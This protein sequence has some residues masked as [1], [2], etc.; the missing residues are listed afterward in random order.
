MRIHS[1][2]TVILIALCAVTNSHATSCDARGLIATQTSISRT[3]KTIE[4][5]TSV[6]P[7]NLSVVSSTG[8]LAYRRLLI[9]QEGTVQSMAPIEDLIFSYDKS[10]GQVL[11]QCE[12][13]CWRHDFSRMA[14]HM[15][16]IELPS[17]QDGQSLVVDLKQLQCLVKRGKHQ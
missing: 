4:P 7:L 3:I 15:I 12:W 6:K 8:L 10:S 1:R 16:V 17:G 2:I 14:K 13:D 11:M 5:D 9:P